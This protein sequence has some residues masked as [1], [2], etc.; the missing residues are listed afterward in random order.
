MDGIYV[1][2]LAA[3]LAS[4][5]CRAVKILGQLLITIGT[6]YVIGVHHR[7]TSSNAEGVAPAS[8]SC[9]AASPATVRPASA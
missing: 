2:P 6:A 1:Y 8:T 3:T 9:L 7:D 5:D 4:E